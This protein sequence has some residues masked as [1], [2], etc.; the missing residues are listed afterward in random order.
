DTWAQ[1]RRV[2]IVRDAEIESLV[3]DYSEPIMRAA[4]VRSDRIDIVLVN[5][6]S[7]N[8]F[9]SGQKMF[10]NVGAIVQSETPNELIGV[11]AHEIAHLADGHQDRLR[12]QIDRAKTIATVT[13]V[14]GLSAAVAGAAAG[15]GR[16]ATAAAGLAASG[17]EIAR[18]GLLAYRRTEELAADRGAVEFLNATGQS[19]QGLLETFKRFQQSLALRASQP[20]PY[21]ISHPL[22]RDRLSSLETLVKA[23]PHFNKKDPPALVQ[24]HDRARAKILAYLYGAGATRSAFADQSG[25]LA[26]RYGEAI[27]AH[28]YGN[29]KDAV[30]KINALIRERPNDAYF[31]EMKGE[32]LLRAQ[33]VPG[34]IAAFTKAVEISR[35]NAPTIQVALGHALVMAGDE[36]S[37]RLAVGELEVA[38]A[39][40]PVNPRAYQRLAMAYGRLGETGNAELATAEANFH[41]GRLKEAKQFAARAKR[42]FERNSPQ[43]LRADDITRFEIPRRR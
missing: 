7:F 10:I 11:I 20:N 1:S 31:H 6:R 34:A 4:G 5:D 16:A 8:A 40:D 21:R 14:I 38:I 37:L 36:Q 17:G 41:G 9:V 24:R 28:L 26:A 30:T 32:I 33:D 42:R 29:P 19:S 22:P 27:A 3:R 39:T 25:S 23:S 15:E 43:W 12:Q 2:P 13:A 18:R 35:G